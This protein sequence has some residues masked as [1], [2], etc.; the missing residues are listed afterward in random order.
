MNENKVEV[1]HINVHCIIAYTNLSYRSWSGLKQ[2]LYDFILGQMKKW[3]FWWNL[4]IKSIQQDLI[5][6]KIQ[7]HQDFLWRYNITILSWRYNITIL[8]WRYNITILSLISMEMDVTEHES[9]S[10]I[11][12]LWNSYPDIITISRLLF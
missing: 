3:W 1:L 5:G 6:R 7:H 8:S 12:V 4:E 2:F 10:F 11:V 9:K